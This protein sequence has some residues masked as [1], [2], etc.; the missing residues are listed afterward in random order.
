MA[1]Q[2]VLT[3][4]YQKKILLEEEC[5]KLAQK[6]DI[7]DQKFKDAA[8][9]ATEVSIRLEELKKTVEDVAKHGESALDTLS[10]IIKE[11]SM[12]VDSSL[13]IIN[14]TMD[15]MTKLDGKITERIESIKKLDAE[16][17][18]RLD[19]IVADNNKLDLRRK[20]LQIYHERLQLKFD[21]HGLGKVIL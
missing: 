6:R 13:A 17:Q 18:T 7:E 12:T 5:S 8:A 15:I 11:A 4:V 20:D 16:E 19:R 10:S 2:E 3:P 9:S 1:R 21:E 14:H